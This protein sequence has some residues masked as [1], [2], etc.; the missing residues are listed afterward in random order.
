MRHHHTTPSNEAADLARWADDGG[1]EPDPQAR[2]H[3]ADAEWLRVAAALATR[4]HPLA[5][6]DDILVTC[7]HRTRS[8]AP[9]AFFP[10]L[11]ELEIATN[12]FK[13]HPP[14]TLHPDR[15]GDE[16]RYPVA[17]GAFTHEAAH[18]AH[19][20]WTLP[21]HLHGTTLAEASEWLEE[22]RAEHHHLQRRPA[23]RRWLRA[24]IRHLILNNLGTRPP[25]DRW[26]TAQAAALILARRDT[27][28]LEPDETQALHDLAEQILGPGLLAT[29]QTIWQ[30]AHATG[31]TDAAAMEAHARAWCQALAH[32]PHQPP[33]NPDPTAQRRSDALPTAIAGITR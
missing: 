22:S 14:A 21:A 33:P 32:D 9:A 11:A 16:D 2:R 15:H 1:P 28:I 29:L 6:S 25:T 13:P 7:A 5:E 23:D 12:L 10:N 26:T 27:G 18:A 17:W 20:D 3:H 19:S 4:L 24:A 31:D 8:G 30:A